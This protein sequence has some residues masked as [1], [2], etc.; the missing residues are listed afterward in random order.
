MYYSNE[1]TQDYQYSA[2]EV[3]QDSPLLV[4]YRNVF[5]LMEYAI[6]LMNQAKYYQMDDQ[7]RLK[8][9][10]IQKTLFT[11]SD[12][13]RQLDFK[14]IIGLDNALDVMLTCVVDCLD[15]ASWQTGHKYL[16]EASQKFYEIKDVWLGIIV[17]LETKA[18]CT[19][20]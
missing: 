10:A 17:V 1:G 18:T 5:Q 3:P 4:S 2:R 15:K 8:D 7:H 12:L 9:D 16:N 6:N 19:V 11:V 20:H 13:R 14:S